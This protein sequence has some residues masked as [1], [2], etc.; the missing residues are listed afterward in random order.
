[1]STA[2]EPVPPAGTAARPAAT[3][4]DRVEPV[5]EAEL[6]EAVDPELVAHRLASRRIHRLLAL[7]LGGLA[8]VAVVVSVAGAGWHWTGLDQNGHL[9]DWLQ[10]L[11]LPLVLLLLPIWIRTHVRLTR[12]W[13]GGFAVLGAAFVVLVIGGYR[14]GWEWT[15]FTGNTLWDWLELLVLP[16]SVSLLPLWLATERRFSSRHTALGALAALAFATVVF[17]GYVIPWAWTG[18]RG[19][20]LWDWVHLFLVPF[21]IP[22]TVTALNLQSTWGIGGRRQEPA[23]Q[24]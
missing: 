2:A 15:G 5:A 11:V 18:F 12:W 23:E 3:P 16:V 4:A 6:V 13:R 24:R 10:L 8:L 21:A 1:M 7:V 14:L 9:W 22:A 19:N 17:C 20:T